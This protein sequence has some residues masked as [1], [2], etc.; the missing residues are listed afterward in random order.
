MSL[1]AGPRPVAWTRLFFTS[2]LACILGIYAGDLFLYFAGRFAGRPM[3]RWRLLRNIL[4]ESKLDQASQWLS[5]R[6]ARVIFLSRFTPGLR[7]P[8]Y[9]AAGILKTR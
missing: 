1:R 4:S 6:G 2:V 3:V 9:V 5:D 8:T 7:L